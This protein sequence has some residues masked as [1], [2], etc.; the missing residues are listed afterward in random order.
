MA[1]RDKKRDRAIQRKGLKIFRFT[2]SE[3]WRN[4]EFIGEIISEIDEIRL[5]EFRRVE[6]TGTP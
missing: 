3:I 4:N 1:A 5:R 6:K 2:G